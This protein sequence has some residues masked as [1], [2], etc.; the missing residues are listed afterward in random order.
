[1][2][3]LL[4]TLLCALSLGSLH[5]ATTKIGIVDMDRIYREYYKTLSN[6]ADLD[7]DKSAA[8]EEVDKRLL[9]FNSLRED[10]DKLRKKL[11]D[12]S[13]SAPLK[14]KTQGEAEN[15]LKELESLKRDINEFAQRRQEQIKDKLIRMRKDI[16]EDLHKFVADKSKESGYD[17]VFD[18]SG[19]STSGIEILLFSKDA[20]DFTNDLLKDV[21]K[22]A[23]VDE[24]KATP[25]K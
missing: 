7:K 13:I 1:M 20:I 5:A 18:R 19:R 15:M 24:K 14:A 21:N 3:L 12:T 23:P 4:T 10:F 9:K 17:L 8:K 6:E 2:K 25:V 11:G 22:D 16:L